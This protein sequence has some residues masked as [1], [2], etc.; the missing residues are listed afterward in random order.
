MVA[1]ILDEDYRP[2]LR[3]W[4]PILIGLSLLF[5]PTWWSLANGIWK[6]D[7]NGSGP[8]ILVVALYLIWLE[9]SVLISPG[10][11]PRPVLG[12]GLLILG[13]LMYVL[14]RSQGILP[15][16]VSSEIPVLFGVLLIA[17]GSKAAR[18]LLFP[19]LFL[20]FMVP[21]PS[22]VVDQLTGPLKQFVSI[23][24]ENILYTLGFPVGRSGVTLT[25]GQYQLLVADAC[26]GLHS[27]F[28]LSALGL[29]Y[30]YLMNYRRMLRIGIILALILPIAIGANVLRVILLILI[31]YYFGDEAG[32]GFAHGFTGLTLFIGGLLL[33]FGL[34]QLVGL[35]IKDKS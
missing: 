5:L 35:V 20:L 30:L 15:I 2:S 22:V 24:A 25:I 16:E 28:S 27:I 3:N 34:D 1:G 26:S 11:S 33:L 4:W 14:G 10:S 8:I 17:L 18:S 29:I 9:R 13:L 31:T 19:I 12:W 23:A 6:T 32:Q 7:E 21:L